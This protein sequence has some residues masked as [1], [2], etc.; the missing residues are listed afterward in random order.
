MKQQQLVFSVIIPTYNRPQRLATC[1]ES[2]TRLDYSRDRF[3]VI[4]VD[5]GS[6]TPIESVV[7]PLQNQL[8]ITL[9]RQANS[10]PATARNTGAAKATGQ[11]LVFTDDDCEV[12][13]D[14]LITL[15]KRFAT[16]PNC[17]IGGK[18]LNAL[19]NNLYSTAS[20]LLI[21]YLYLYFNANFQESSFFASNNFALPRELFHI[22]GGFDTTFP[23]AAGEDR[24]FCDRW[25]HHGYKMLY[26]PE[27]RIYHAH[28]LTLPAF[29]RQHFNYGRG[30]F[31]FHQARSQRVNQQ[32][33]VEPFSFY[34][35]LLTYPLSQTSP[36]PA[37][38]ISGL[39]FMSQIAN[40]VG[41]FW[42]RLRQPT[43]HLSY[44]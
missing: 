14:W 31:C 24:E 1:L 6:Q 5:D 2:L 34:F 16:A 10:G 9:I 8:S 40:V 38:L 18:T 42:E 22:L 26:A 25:Q 32:I 37:L 7:A 4:V 12:A 13:S 29:W 11:F 23:L 33:K 19:P 3:E 17:L 36:Q 20:Q 15:E 21:D 44:K 41:F 27:V 39:F 28:K 30:A 43:H 35:K